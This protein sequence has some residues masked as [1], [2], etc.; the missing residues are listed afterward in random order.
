MGLPAQRDL[1]SRHCP[2]PVCPQAALTPV[3]AGALRLLPPGSRAW[4][5]PPLSRRPLNMDGTG[6][7]DGEQWGLSPAATAVKGAASG[8]PPSSSR[9]EDVRKSGGAA[10]RRASSRSKRTDTQAARGGGDV[11]ATGSGGSVGQGAEAAEAGVVAL[12][13]PDMGL[14]LRPDGYPCDADMIRRYICYS[15]LV[16]TMV[17]W[18]EMAKVIGLA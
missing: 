9:G 17:L 14:D 6:H 18:H 3:V 11:K 15:F 12:S 5:Q 8:E 7:R 10:A 2:R 13:G 4:L 1:G 16:V